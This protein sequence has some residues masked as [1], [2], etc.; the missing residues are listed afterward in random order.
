MSFTTVNY[1]TSPA[2]KLQ[3]KEAAHSRFKYGSPKLRDLLRQQCRVR[4]KERR[5]NNFLGKRNLM[6][7]ERVMMT[8]VVKESISQFEQNEIL[9]ELIYKEL[10]EE[11]EE[12]LVEDTNYLAELAMNEEVICPLCQKKS[13]AANAFFVNCDFC[14]FR[15]KEYQDLSKL[16]DRIKIVVLQHE[17]ICSNTLAFFAEPKTRDDPMSLSINAICDKCEYFSVV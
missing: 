8:G 7:E 3:S 12:W 2:S 16:G 15:T 13:L 1:I 17:V 9:Q 5:N 10:E 11:M 6:E 14:G 4:F